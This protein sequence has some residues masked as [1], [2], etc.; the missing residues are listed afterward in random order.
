MKSM[1]RMRDLQPKVN[2]LRAKHKADPR[3]MN[4]EM[5][6]LYKKEGV[7]PMN[8][9]C[10]PMFLQMPI[11]IS[12][13][14][15][16]RKAIELRGTGTWVVPWVHD[17]S[18]AEM[19]FRLPFEIPFYGDNF[20]LMPIVMAVVTFVQNKMTIKDPNQIAMIYLMPII[21][22]V[23]FNSFPAGLVLY[24]TLSSALGLV[25]QKVIDRTMQARSQAVVAGPV[26]D[27]GKSERIRGAKKK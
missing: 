1:S 27:T 2:A 22:L 4:E 18:Q 3:K 5:M 15:V 21:M 8:F 25:Q 20:A 17:L 23:M 24:W 14:V 26:V 6:A 11:L 13:Y 10:L 16:L 12:L 9:G 7:N 19:L